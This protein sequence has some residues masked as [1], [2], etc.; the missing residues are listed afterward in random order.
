MARIGIDATGITERGMG[1]SR[2]LRNIIFSLSQLSEVQHEFVVFHRFYQ[3]VRLPFKVPNW[4]FVQVPFFKQILWDQWELPRLIIKYHLDLIHT[5]YDRLPL[6]GRTPFVMQL[7]EMPHYRVAAQRKAGYFLKWYQRF[8]EAYYLSVFPHSLRKASLVIVSSQWTK[9]DL[10]ETFQIPER[11]IRVVPLACESI[12]KPVDN[13]EALIKIRAR[14]SRGDPY[15]L[16]FS[17]GDPRDNTLVVLEAFKKA[18]EKLQ[19][20]VKLVIVGNDP[21]WVDHFSRL[22]CELKDALVRYEDFLTDEKLVDLYRGADLYVDPSLYEGFGL[23]VLEAMACGVPVLTSKATAIEEI[24]D[25]CALL[26]DHHSADEFC[27]AMVEVL[28]NPDLQEQLRSKGVRQARRYSWEQTAQQT[29]AAFEQILQE[30]N[31]P[32][33]CL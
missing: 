20:K 5:A 21:K 14:I 28:S 19:R 15:I 11:K 2:Y 30:Q 22:E 29:L 18:F 25:G 12:F 23:Q 3:E 6:F 1:L 26:R 8:S 13:K 33:R 31:Q 7:F 27:Q 17:N 4:E 10:I 16:H 32:V 24:A 9:E